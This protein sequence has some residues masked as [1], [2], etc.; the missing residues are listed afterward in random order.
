LIGFWGGGVL[1]RG[2][3]FG[4][5]KKTLKLAKKGGCAFSDFLEAWGH[6]AEKARGEDF[7]GSSE[8]R[9]DRTKT[10]EMR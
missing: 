6:S 8:K 3:V 1:K 9:E 5:V 10:K 7:E 4:G 2:R